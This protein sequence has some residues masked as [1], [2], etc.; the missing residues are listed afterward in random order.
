[1]DP[2]LR[3]QKWYA[4]RCVDHRE[5]CPGSCFLDMRGGVWQSGLDA[6]GGNVD[7]QVGH[8]DDWGITIGS[9]S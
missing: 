1:M 8:Y 5:E 2:R 4:G 3:T 7:F 6:F 9:I